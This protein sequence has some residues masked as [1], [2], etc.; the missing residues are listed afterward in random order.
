MTS[1]KDH[2]VHDKVHL[3]CMDLEDV[4]DRLYI[5]RKQ[6]KNRYAPKDYL[7]NP[8]KGEG[9]HCLSK[10]NIAKGN[11]VVDEFCR[12]QIVEWSFRVV[13]YFR[14]NREVVAIST[15]YLD[16]FLAT[17]SCDRKTFKL[18]ATTALNLAVKLNEST[19]TDM[20]SV[21]SELSRGEFSMSDIVEMEQTMIESLSWLLHPPTPKCILGYMLKLLPSTVIPSLIRSISALSSFFTELSLCDYYFTTQYPS[22]VALAAILNS[23]EILN[24]SE[25]SSNIHNSFLDQLSVI[26]DVHY[27]S[28]EV[29]EAR[30]RLWI[31]YERSEEFTIQSD[32]AY[33]NNKHT[34]AFL[35]KNRRS[36]RNHQSPVSVSRN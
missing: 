19:K 18:A 12:E 27:E 36:T 22:T 30:K 23:M 15:S 16:R 7:S 32:K 14:I 2:Q 24:L 35:Q 5:M 1:F 17:C 10:N 9:K 20:M 6:E 34:R 28:E 8:L 33:S 25:I 26:I 29:L 4:I 31:V 3:S 13:D 21:L 11:N